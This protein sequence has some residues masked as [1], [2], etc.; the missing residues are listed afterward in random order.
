[1]LTIDDLRAGDTSND[2][3]HAN[4]G[5]G[6]GSES[7]FAEPGAYDMRFFTVMTT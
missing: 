3:G 6:N 4:D 1:M 7:N 5:N 2:W